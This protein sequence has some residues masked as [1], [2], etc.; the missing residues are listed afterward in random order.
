MNYKIFLV[1]LSTVD[2]RSRERFIESNNQIASLVEKFKLEGGAY[3]KYVGTNA[4]EEN[5]EQHQKIP[6]T[7]YGRPGMTSVLFT[8]IRYVHRKNIHCVGIS[9]AC[10]FFPSKTFLHIVRF[11]SCNF[12]R[13]WRQMSPFNLTGLKT[14][15]LKLWLLPAFY[16]LLWIFYYDG[17][18]QGSDVSMK[19][20]VYICSCLFTFFFHLGKSPIPKYLRHK[21][22]P[23]FQL[24]GG[25]LFHVNHHYCMHK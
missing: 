24:P 1:C 21:K 2:R 13:S 23:C 10:I 7:A 16:F 3:R 20:I 22:W 8:L 9:K 4:N 14:F 5:I 17:F 15:L 6:L 11:F 12:S 18:A 25:G 19:Q